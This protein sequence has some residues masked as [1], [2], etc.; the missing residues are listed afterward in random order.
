VV[1]LWKFS[2]LHAVQVRPAA[3]TN[4]RVSS[5]RIIA[6]GVPAIQLNSTQPDI[7]DAGVNTSISASMYPTFLKHH[8]V[9]TTPDR[10]PVPVRSA[11][12]SNLTPKFL[13]SERLSRRLRLKVRYKYRLRL[14][15]SP[16][17]LT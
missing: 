14:K 11:V 7:T 6:G 4:R 1:L 10:F 8:Q 3:P 2:I 12:K 16:T 15:L 9:I 5:S 17:N 13:L